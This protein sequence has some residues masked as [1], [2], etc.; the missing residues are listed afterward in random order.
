MCAKLNNFLVIS[1]AALNWFD[2]SSPLENVFQL[3][4]GLD[5]SCQGEEITTEVCQEV[6]AVA[7]FQFA[8]KQINTIEFR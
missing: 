8:F 1:D 4:I 2:F 7:L 6:S 3:L 5:L